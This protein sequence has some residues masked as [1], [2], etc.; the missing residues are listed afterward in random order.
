M[1]K[2]EERQVM[3]GLEIH[4]TLMTKTKL[5]CSCQTVQ[6]Y[7]LTISA[8]EGFVPPANTF[9]CPTC[10]GHPGS[11]PVVNSNAVKNSMK[12]CLAMQCK[13][14]PSLIFSR[15]AYFYPDLSKNYQITQFEEPLGRNGKL[16]LQSGREIEISRIHL[17]EDPA[18]LEYPETI[19][20]SQF[21]LIDYNRAGNPL[22]EIVTSPNINNPQEAREALNQLITII[23]YLG[24][25]DQRYC[26]I[27]A[28]ANISI[29]ESSFTR[30][31]VKNITSFKEIESAL[32]FEIT[33]QKMRVNR[34]LK[35][36]RETR[37]WD[38]TSKT[39]KPLRTKESEEDYGYIFD[40]DLCP[41]EIGKDAIERVKKEIPELH[42][43]KIKRFVKEYKIAKDDALVLSSDIILADLFEDV[44][45]K[46][47]PQLTAKWLRRELLRVLNFADKTIRDDA[48]NKEH[49]T[50]LLEL[51]NAKKIT[52]RTAQKMMNELIKKD[53]SPKE[54]VS[55]QQLG[56]I[57]D[58]K[59]I[60][61]MCSEAIKE[62]PKAAA[63]FKS[64]KEESL[65][66]LFGQVMRK[67]NGKAEPKIVKKVLK[68]LLV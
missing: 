65:H 8:D 52:E 57:D 40:P 23:E 41:T 66:F 10:L 43:E 31:E 47:N 59:E 19:T 48:I 34:G 36:E 21:S 33:R 3:I 7:E 5:F 30:V 50:E 53:F 2:A 62:N 68:K 38:A 9:V 55:S 18:S 27:K 12:L 67:T 46:V 24:I 51:L 54:I 14:S 17:E 56:K 25:F 11:K 13:I 44:A 28:D 1:I 4:I 63:D 32:N 60:Q 15:K 20:T 6:N 29:K 26:S 42:F 58:K 16:L 45:G 35:I 61:K 37:S 39:T 49:L 64:G 22:C